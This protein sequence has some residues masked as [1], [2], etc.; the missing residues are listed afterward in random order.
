MA[1]RGRGDGELG[2]ADDLILSCSSPKVPPATARL[3]VRALFRHYGGTRAYVR[4]GNAEMLGVLADAVGDAAAG[5]IM[6]KMAALYGGRQVYFPRGAMRRTT[7]LEIFERLGKNGT[8]MADLAREHG[9]SD[10]HGYD[11]WREGRAERLRPSAPYLPFPEINNP[12]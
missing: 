2:L 6:G 4:E 12:D 3:A 10:S 5:R 7:A 8:T 11:L 1:R 9:I